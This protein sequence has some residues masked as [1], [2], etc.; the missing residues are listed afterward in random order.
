LGKLGNVVNSLLKQCSVSLFG[1]SN[2]VCI[3]LLAQFKSIVGLLGIIVSR[4]LE[5]SKNA[6]HGKFGKMVSKLYEQFRYLLL[7]SFG[8]IIN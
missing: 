7:G 6:L 2:I 8:S 3:L 5:Q 4:L 1:C